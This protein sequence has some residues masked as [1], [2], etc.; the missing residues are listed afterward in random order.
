MA[1]ACNASKVP[2]AF[3]QKVVEMGSCNCIER[4]GRNLANI[5]GCFP[6]GSDPIS[7]VRCATHTA[8]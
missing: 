6:F 3:S 1:L 4:V 2:D 7:D 5:F 8:L